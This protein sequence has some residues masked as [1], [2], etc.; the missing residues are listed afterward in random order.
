MSFYKV[1]KTSYV[2]FQDRNGR[3]GP[4]SAR[5]QYKEAPKKELDKA[6]T[7]GANSKSAAPP[8]RCLT[9]SSTTST[10]P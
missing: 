6:E 9:S 4:S 3:W 10:R 7:A 2:G 8:C 5:K 1:G